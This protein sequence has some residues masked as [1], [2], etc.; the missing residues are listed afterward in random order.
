M[1]WAN[2][3]T[4]KSRAS[5][6][7]TWSRPFIAASAWLA[8]NKANVARGEQPKAKAVAKVAKGAEMAFDGGTT[9]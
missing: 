2:T 5:R 6:G 1:R 4:A 7:I 8:R 3:Q 9:H